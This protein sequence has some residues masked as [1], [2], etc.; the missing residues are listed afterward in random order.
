MNKSFHFVPDFTEWGNR[1]KTMA[2]AWNARLA[3][4]AKQNASRKSMR[5]SQVLDGV[6]RS[7]RR[8]DVCEA[9]AWNSENQRKK[10]RS[11][12]SCAPKSPSD[13]WLLHAGYQKF[14]F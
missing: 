14:P 3:I 13:R 8:T 2:V 12:Y 7:S 1:P 6:K 5:R 11:W 9:D 10:G 4:W